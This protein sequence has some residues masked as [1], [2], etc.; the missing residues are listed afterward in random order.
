MKDTL[1]ERIDSSRAKT[2]LLALLASISFACYWLI[3]AIALNPRLTIVYDVQGA[4]YGG[5]LVWPSRWL[6]LANL[7]EDGR[8]WFYLALVGALTV[9]WLAAIYLVRNDRRRSTSLIIGGAFLMFGLLFVFGPTFQ[10]KDVFSYSFHGRAMSVYHKNPFLLIPNLRRHDVFYPLVGWKFNASVYGP[11]FNYLSYLITKLAGDNIA[12]NVLGFKLLAFGAYTACLP[13][14]YTLAKRVKP[15][16]ENM[17][18]AISAWCPVLVMHILGAGHNDILMVALILAGFLLYRKGYLL[19]GM[20]VVLLA[21]LVKV[22]AVL[23]LAPM[24]VLYVR[25]NNG[26]PLKRLVKG[27]AVLG[28]TTLILYAPF[29]QTLDIFKTTRHMAKV[30]SGSSVPRLISFQY[31]K[32]LIQGGMSP[33]R[34]EEVANGRVQLLFVALLAVIAVA[35]LLRVKDYPTM[36][37]GAAGLFLAWFLTSSYILAWYVAA[38]L[39]IAAILGWNFTTAAMVGMSAIFGLYRIPEPRAG[40]FTYGGGPN[41]YLSVPFLLLLAGWLL[42]P[43]VKRL[44]ERRR[45]PVEAAVPVAIEEI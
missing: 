44:W 2:G 34:A 42:I 23:A 36:V 28:G 24:F 4:K 37:A 14:V 32:F 29:L 16:K 39:L 17:A 15:G 45:P 19:T 41:L 9:M 27:G 13:L 22:N 35:L 6:R 21:A 1:R 38:G 40:G 30:Y 3:V 8:M 33:F 18:L 26:A 25:D 5:P 43:L 7:T 12:A 10:S 11:V 20:V 31:Q